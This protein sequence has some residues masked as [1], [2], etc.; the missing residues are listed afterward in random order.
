M[1]SVPSAGLQVVVPPPAHS[2][3]PLCVTDDPQLAARAARWCGGAALALGNPALDV[4][5]RGLVVAH[6]DGSL[7]CAIMR[8]GDVI[9]VPVIRTGT[10]LDTLCQGIIFVAH[11]IIAADGELDGPYLHVYL[12]PDTTA[13]MS[14]D[15]TDYV[16]PPGEPPQGK[17]TAHDRS[18]DTAKTRALNAALSVSLAVHAGASLRDALKTA[19]APILR[20]SA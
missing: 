20:T 12:Q 19:T 11:I 17:V 8:D 10:E 6:G 14:G 1:S 18:A 16:D 5:A 3:V 2:D 13:G 15:R 4:L 9:A 7:R